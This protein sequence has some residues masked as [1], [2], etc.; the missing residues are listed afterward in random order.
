MQTFTA[1][2]HQDILALVTQIAV[3]LFTARMF[4]ELAQRLKQPSV[5]GE[6]LAGIILGPS[7]LSKIFPFLRGIVIP[8][9]GVQGYLLEAISLIGAMFLLLITG[10]ETDLNLIRRY[11]RVALGVSAGG[12][13]T[14]FSS[15]FIL[16]QF[17]P[18]FLIAENSD[19]L[20]FS[21]FVA[22]AMSISAIPVIAKVLID[23]KL[24][25]RNVGQIIIASGMSDDTIGW[26]LLSIVAGLAAG[27]TITATSISMAITQ[28]LA[29]LLSVLRLVAGLSKNL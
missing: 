21:L 12:I 6:I 25:R 23:L 18:D 9:Y 27:K 8:E 16:G 29:F 11:S 1:A 3:L 17:L 4:G 20:V 28:V 7:C 10:L 5:V 22:T 19:R 26:I 14:T 2:S 13:I 15:G 24:M